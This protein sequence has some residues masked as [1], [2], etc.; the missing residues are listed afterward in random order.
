[1][2]VGKL[3]FRERKGRD[4]PSGGRFGFATHPST[5]S[6]RPHGLCA[7]GPWAEQWAVHLPLWACQSLQ[8]CIWLGEH[9]CVLINHPSGPPSLPHR[10]GIWGLGPSFHEHT[11]KPTV[12]SRKLGL[13]G[14]G[15]LSM[16]VTPGL[17]PFS[18]H[19][20]LPCAQTFLSPL[21]P[22]SWLPRARRATTSL[23]LGMVT[24]LA[25]MAHRLPGVPT[26]SQASA[27]HPLPLF[28]FCIF[29]GPHPQHMEV[30]RLGVDLSLVCNLCHGSQQRQILA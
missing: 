2:D 24:K 21:P 25:A 7:H 15:Q 20:G 10:P 11:K 22:W 26:W 14:A 1:M 5:S 28:P 17:W 16:P 6:Q 18:W 9:I 19:A 4:L 3:R 13:G 12:P 8:S 27:H 29:L 23:S 30:P